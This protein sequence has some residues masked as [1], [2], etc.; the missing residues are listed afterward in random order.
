MQDKKITENYYKKVIYSSVLIF[1][2]LS[3]FPQMNISPSGEA[4]RGTFPMQ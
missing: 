1:R 3:T 2:R 4:A